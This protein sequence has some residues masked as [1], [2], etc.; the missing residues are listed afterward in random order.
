VRL[1][2]APLAGAQEDGAWGDFSR[3]REAA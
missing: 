1:R 2:R 3:G